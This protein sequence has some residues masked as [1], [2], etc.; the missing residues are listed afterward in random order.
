MEPVRVKIYGLVSL[1]RR[2]YLIQVVFA[3]LLIGLLLA[4]WF[5]VYLPR[6]AEMKAGDVPP[7]LVWVVACLDAIPWLAVLFVV[8]QA[9]EAY[10]VLRAFRRKEAAP[11]PTP[12][13]GRAP[14]V[15]PGSAAPKTSPD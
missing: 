11:P 14:D 2:R 1:T 12:S 13:E 10:V 5:R 7:N 4:G 6:R 15:S 9:V 3:V 8:W